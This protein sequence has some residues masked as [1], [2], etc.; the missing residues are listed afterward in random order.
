MRLNRLVLG[1]AVI[2]LNVLPVVAIADNTP[3]MVKDI[4]FEGLMRVSPASLYAQLP[5]NNGDR[6]DEAKISDLV[7]LLF[8]TGSFEDVVAERDGDVLIFRLT[9]RP[10][11][12]AIKL[13][14]N[15]AIDTDTL[16]K[17]LKDAGLTEGE[18]LKRATLDHIKGEL[19]RQYFSQGRYDASITVNHVAKPRN[20]VGD[21]N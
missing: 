12:A 1:S 5:L 21:R 13:E 18:V 8:K 2:A 17:A 10:A 4:R 16:M 7:R 9:E 15:K 11:I 3:F 14:G 19:Q 20:R 6:V